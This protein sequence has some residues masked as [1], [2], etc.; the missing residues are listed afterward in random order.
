MPIPK[1]SNDDM[2]QFHD[3]LANLKRQQMERETGVLS[4]LMNQP[5]AQSGRDLG[6][7]EADVAARK[8]EYLFK[9]SNEIEDCKVAYKEAEDLTSRLKKHLVQLQNMYRILSK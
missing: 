6:T 5:S 2:K 9:I 7:Y 8:N 4:E 1:N 3:S